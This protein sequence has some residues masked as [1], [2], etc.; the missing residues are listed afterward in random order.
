VAVADKVAV[1]VAVAEGVL[2]GVS[3]DG[4]GVLEGDAVKVG[5]AVA[6]SV[7]SDVGLAG[8]VV[9]VSPDK[10]LLSVG[11]EVAGSNN[12]VAVGLASLFNVCVGTAIATA[13]FAVC[14]AELVGV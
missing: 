13:V 10:L 11:D 6:V 3:L 8:I 1:R 12:E 9:A 5:W 14:A 7:G 2:V 4:S